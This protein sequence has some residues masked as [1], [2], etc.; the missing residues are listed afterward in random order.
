MQ[1]REIFEKEVK[2]WWPEGKAF[3][4]STLDAAKDLW[5]EGDKRIREF[6][7]DVLAKVSAVPAVGAKF[8]LQ[9]IQPVST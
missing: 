7:R 3:E 5:K 1:F 9:R 8:L 2:P 6:D 4:N